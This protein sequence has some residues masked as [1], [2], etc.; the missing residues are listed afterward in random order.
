SAEALR[1][2]PVPM[3]IWISHGPIR[4]AARRLRYVLCARGFTE[5]SVAGCRGT[6]NGHILQEVEHEAR[7]VGHGCTA[8]GSD[9]SGDAAGA[10]GMLL[11]LGAWR[12]GSSR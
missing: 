11:R 7:E 2:C 8:A 6:L 10:V 12:Q 3:A 1:N 5:K 9:G 4:S